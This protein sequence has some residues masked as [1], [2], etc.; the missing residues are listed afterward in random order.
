MIIKNIVRQ[1]D[2]VASRLLK[3]E[4]MPDPFFRMNEYED[5]AMI[6]SGISCFDYKFDAEPEL[7][8]KKHVILHLS[9]IDTVAD[10][11][12]N[13]GNLLH[14]SDMFRTYETDVK[15]ILRE[16]ENTLS[17]RII[18]PRSVMQQKKAEPSAP[19]KT[20]HYVPSGCEDGNQ[21]IRKA[22]SMSGWDWGIDLPDSG[23]YGDVQIMAFDSRIEDVHIRQLHKEGTVTVN[24]EVTVTDGDTEAV[25]VCI[26]APDGTEYEG[27]EVRISSPELWWPSNLGG[28]PLYRVTVKYRDE[29]RE[30]R[31]GLRTFTVSRE[32]ASWG[33]E[34][35]FMVNGVKFFAMGADYIPDDAIYPRITDEKLR[36]MVKTAHDSNYNCLRVWG[37]GYY[38]RDSFYDYCDEYGIIVWQDFMFACNIYDLTPELEDDI[39]NEAA[40]NIRRL[41][42]HA[43]LGLWCGNNEMESGWSHW[44]GFC[45]HSDALRRDYLR[46][47]ENIL[48]EAV[49]KYD[50]EHFYWPSSPSSGGNFVNPD[51]ENDGDTH[52]WEVWHGEKP[53]EEFL[54]HKF[55]FCSEFGFQSFPSMKTIRTFAQKDDMN[56]FSRVMESHQKNE[57]ANG[58]MLAYIARYFRY[59]KDFESVV[60]VTQI[61]QALAIKAGVEHFRRNRGK[62]MGAL[63]W[64]MNDNWP[65]A[66]WASVDYFGRWKPLQYAARKFFR[67]AAG[68][69]FVKD[70]RAYAYVT[71]ETASDIKVKAVI[72]IKKFDFSV[73]DSVE[74]EIKAGS[75]S[76]A[77]IA[78]INAP[79]SYDTFIEAVFYYEDGAVSSETAVTV[80]YKHLELKK[81]D[82]KVEF[83]GGKVHIIS[84]TYTPFVFLDFDDGDALFENN[85]FDITGPEGV[86]SGY[87]TVSGTCSR[88][89]IISLE[90]SYAQED[91]G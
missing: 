74:R 4:K 18:P 70:G 57:A 84:D 17:I 80:P 69:L 46:I 30:Y 23:I 75:F 58:K 76:A 64:Q 39:R 33:R 11:V 85:M 21:Y 36:L 78:E 91:R 49:R 61:L 59:P 82:I 45:D 34:F 79:V 22:H 62:C 60:Y 9:G 55:N 68:S 27:S 15:E 1:P 16:G 83:G 66:S 35:C 63:Y 81:P 87:D 72:R 8:A 44:P 54:N 3:E 10:I 90:Q 40:D 12:M 73:I 52:F 48:P 56:I 89:K 28:Q 43:S 53:F 7:L 88:I 19:D 5:A 24:T 37:G 38:P 47:F 67:P 31:I 42:H 6:N 26:K 41:R 50:G 29:V 13:G 2:S 51:D 65:V 71:N 86:T 14:T 32:K 20:I 25:S 77:E